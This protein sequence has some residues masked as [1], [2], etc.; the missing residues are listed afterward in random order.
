MDAKSYNPISSFY[1]ERFGQK[2]QKIPV[3]L[4]QTCPNRE[5]LKDMKVCIFCDEWGSAAYE[6]S[7]GQPVETQIL[8]HREKLRARY[9]ANL[10]LVYFQAY[11]NTFLKFQTLKENIDKA[12]SFDDVA[13]VVVGT[14]PDC[15]SDV[16]LRYWHDLSQ[17]KFVGVELG[18]QSFFDDQLLYLSRG[19]TAEDSIRA[20]Q[21][22]RLSAP[23]VDL[24][25][26]LMF[27][28]K[29]ENDEHIVKT[30]EICNSLGIDN[31]KLHNLHVLKN[32]PL[33]QDYLAQT[34]EPIDLETYTHRVCLFLQHLSP[35]IAV[36]RL[37]AVSSRWDELVAPEWVRYKMKNTQ[38]ILD[39]MKTRRVY[40]GQLYQKQT[41]PSSASQVSDFR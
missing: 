12:M 16:L 11:T 3:S 9:K 29:N 23:Q 25:I 27:G 32:T 5:N 36:H 40:Q 13:G 19:H 17:I 14:R 7:Q 18:V 15:L 37:L 10:F 26:H 4:A 41:R 20:I 8:E 24:G 28:L 38:F 33:E 1:F 35:D 31:V 2:V 6:N 39:T 22:I 21:K 30:A 34:F